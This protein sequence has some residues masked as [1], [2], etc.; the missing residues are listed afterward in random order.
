MNISTIVE[1]HVVCS[2][3]PIDV[4][5]SNTILKISDI[6]LD[7]ADV[8]ECWWFGGCSIPIIDRRQ[9]VSVWRNA[10]EIIIAVVVDI[11]P[12]YTTGITEKIRAQIRHLGECAA[13]VVLPRAEGKGIVGIPPTDN[14]IVL[15]TIESC[16]EPLVA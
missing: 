9:G 13:S 4:A 5:P 6:F 3:I 16:E 2:T 10:K 12:P 7:H 8:L 11:D 14:I 15:G 1:N